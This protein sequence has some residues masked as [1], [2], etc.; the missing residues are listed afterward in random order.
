M[1]FLILKIEVS[2]FVVTCNLKLLAVF[3]ALEIRFSMTVSRP[4]NSNRRFS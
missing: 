4:P 2:R 3:L 1:E